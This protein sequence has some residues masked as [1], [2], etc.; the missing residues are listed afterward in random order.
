MSVITDFKSAP[1]DIFS[2]SATNTSGGI[3]NGYT[4]T[5]LN[6]IPD[7]SYD[8]LLGSRWATADGRIL[9]LASNAATALVNGV[10]VQSR[11]ETTAF[12]KLAITVPA[13]TPAT[14]G[15]NQ[16]LVTNGSTVL[17]V[18]QFAG[19]YLIVASGSNLLGQTLKIA[20]HQAAANAATFI[21]TT[22]DPIQNTLTASCTVSLVYN[23]YR[24]IIINPTTA[25]GTPVGITLYPVPASTAAT[26]NA[27]TGALVTAGTPQYC[28]ILASGVTGCLIDS[29]VTNVGYPLGRSAATAGALGVATLT[30]VAQVGISAQ[31][32]TSAQC[33]LVKIWL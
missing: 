13:A 32:Q 9:A 26:F 33:G 28:F 30:T 27:T 10:L 20:S 19:G 22:E 6:S 29:T 2:P 17:N 15:T 31:T 5:G 16:I 24:E 25:T 21:V 3:Y 11:A 8:A 18:N 23:P 7:Y 12:Q 4:G 1:F 14:V